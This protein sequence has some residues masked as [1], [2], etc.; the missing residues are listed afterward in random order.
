MKA[1]V[2]LETTIPS[3]HTSW[4]S[5]DIL[6]AAEQEVTREWWKSRDAFDLYVLEL[7]MDETSRLVP[8]T[9]RQPPGDL[10]RLQAYSFWE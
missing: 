8:A 1:R 6:R 4:P 3:Y 2:Y 5:R 7:V 10:N 9:P